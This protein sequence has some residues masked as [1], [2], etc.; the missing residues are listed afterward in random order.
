[1][2]QEVVNFSVSGYIQNANE[3][4]LGISSHFPQQPNNFAR[5]G[6]V[7]WVPEQTVGIH[8]GWC[9]LSP[10]DPQEQMPGGAGSGHW[11]ILILLYC[12]CKI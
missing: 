7:V 1:M 4:C 12:Y 6:G 3:I 8:W 2:S 11:E 9:L 5:G 10:M